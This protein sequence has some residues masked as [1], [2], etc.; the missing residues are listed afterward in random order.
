MFSGPGMTATRFFES[1]PDRDLRRF[2]DP[3]VL[4]ILDAIFGGRIAGDDLQRV[5]RTLVDLDV[6]LG[7]A[8]GRR[9]VLSLL[10]EQKRTEL[11]GRIG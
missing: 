4:S 9:L 11:E 6:M 5:A 2:L 1:I 10:P 7:E 8:K 3:G